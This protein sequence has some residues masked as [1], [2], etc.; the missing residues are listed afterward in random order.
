MAASR[1][2]LL[3]LASILVGLAAGALVL[4]AGGADP[5]KGIYVLLTSFT[6]YPEILLVGASITMLTGLAFAIPL[7][8]GFFNIGGEGQLYAGAIVS[9]MVSLV[10]PYTPFPGLLAG[11]TAGAI[12]GFI[13]GFLRVRLGVNEVL[14]TIMLNWAIYWTSTYLVIDVLADPIYPHLTRQVPEAARIP[15]IP[16][17]LL[18]PL[19]E[20]L[21]GGVPIIPFISIAVALAAWAAM[22]LTVP[23]L[24]YR[25]VGANEYAALS[26]GVNVDYVKLASMTVAGGLSGL[27]GALL[28]LGYSYR[29][30]TGL[31]G[32]AGYG[33]EGIGAA[34]IGRNHPLGIIAAS[35]FLGELAAGSERI[36]VEANVPAE[37]AEVVS[38]AIIFVLAALSG[39]KYVAPRLLG[40]KSEG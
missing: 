30:D 35:V 32:L 2:L 27:A 9:L 39:L 15:W 36:Q 38:G 20:V 24:R 34:L 28:I 11:F 14:S 16:S 23:G 26:R 13:A 3:T 17:S 21:P 10:A 19:S 22:Y 5:L 33:F 18:G 1:E 25:F 12:L 7:R 37:L 6:Y 8:V 40:V 29:V 4:A 31:S